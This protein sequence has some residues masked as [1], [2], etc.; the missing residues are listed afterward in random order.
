MCLYIN[1]VDIYDK[2]AFNKDKEEFLKRLTKAG[3]RGIIVYKVYAPIEETTKYITG[4][5][6]T[7]LY[8]RSYFRQNNK[9]IYYSHHTCTHIASHRESN[10]LTPSEKRLGEVHKGL[11]VYIDYKH[12]LELSKE[13]QIIKVYKCR[14]YKRNLVAV[15]DFQGK[16]SAVFHRLVVYN[17][18]V[19]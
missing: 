9:Y 12:A 14:V 18:P 7:S 17:K 19:S 4:T 13:S 5:E 15:G 8:L 1:P 2:E 6:H 3:D 11:H 16:I 10:L